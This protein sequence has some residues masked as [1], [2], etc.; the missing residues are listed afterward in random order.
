MRY[1]TGLT[2]RDAPGSFEE[3]F[4]RGR[5]ESKGLRVPWRPGR[6]CPA[7]SPVPRPAIDRAREG[8]LSADWLGTDGAGGRGNGGTP[9]WAPPGP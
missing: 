9:S 1:M 3:G 7:R 5:L 6:V 8:R 4:L 2:G